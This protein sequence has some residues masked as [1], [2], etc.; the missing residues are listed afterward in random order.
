LI[1]EDQSTT[2]LK[3]R[4]QAFQLFGTALA[5]TFQSKEE[6]KTIIEQKVG[7]LE[8]SDVRKFYFEI[9]GM[10]PAHILE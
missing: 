5:I 6:Q 10:K 8:W 3:F 9:I 2:G 1:E 7:E 4:H